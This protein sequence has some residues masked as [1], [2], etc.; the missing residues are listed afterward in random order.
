[1]RHYKIN[2]DFM[3]IDEAINYYVHRVLE[4]TAQ[5][6]GYIDTGNKSVLVSRTIHDIHLLSNI[7]A[8]YHLPVSTHT[9]CDQKYIMYV[10]SP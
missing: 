2:Y 4:T 9:Y 10:R 5:L 1:M 7:V 8:V 6:L 3:I